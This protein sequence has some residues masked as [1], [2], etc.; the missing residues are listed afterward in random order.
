MVTPARVAAA[1]C[2]LAPFVGALWVTSYQRLTP[3]LFG[4]PFFYWYQLLWV[5]IGAGLT[6]LAYLLIQAD[7]RARARQAGGNGPPPDPAAGP[8]G[9]EAGGEHA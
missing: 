2:L 3:K 8:G 7:E 9:D 1:G 5:V 6:G 4:F